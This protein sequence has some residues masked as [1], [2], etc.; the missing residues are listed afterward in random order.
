MGEALAVARAA[1]TGGARILDAAQSSFLSGMQAAML[2]GALLMAV[3]VAATLRWLP[4]RARAP[5]VEHASAAD[6][7]PLGVTG[8][9]VVAAGPLADLVEELEY[10]REH[11]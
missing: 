4:A 11:D 5:G 1:P 10:L 3:G 9:D 8:A 6:V 2:V 7:V